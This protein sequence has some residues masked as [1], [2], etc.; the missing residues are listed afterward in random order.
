MMP[1]VRLDI[2]DGSTAKP[3]NLKFAHVHLIDVQHQ[4]LLQLEA[5]TAMIACE[6]RVEVT[7]HPHI[8]TMQC[9]LAFVLHVADGTLE[10]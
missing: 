4:V 10:M 8:V 5:F 2:L 1:L 6:Y 7:V 3:T 9:L